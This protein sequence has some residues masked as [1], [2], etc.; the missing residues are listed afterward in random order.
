M[1]AFLFTIQLKKYLEKPLLPTAQIINKNI[2]LKHGGSGIIKCIT[3]GKPKPNVKW[4]LDNVEIEN[5]NDF[6]ING[7]N[8]YVL[9]ANEKLNQATLTCHASNSEKS[10]AE[11]SMQIN[12]QS[13]FDIKTTELIIN[14]SFVTIQFMNLFFSNKSHFECSFKSEKNLNLNDFDFN[15]YKSNGERM[16][17]SQ[18][19]KL[20]MG[21]LNDSDLGSY[22]CQVENIKTREASNKFYVDLTKFTIL[23]AKA[24]TR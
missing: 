7:N 1:N 21:D 2:K 24:V 13:A 20:F 9:K 22:Y 15:W 11:D 3:S 10:F 8:L 16:T 5:S 18:N 14:P 12:L 19:G 6:V 23:K 4:L 17:T